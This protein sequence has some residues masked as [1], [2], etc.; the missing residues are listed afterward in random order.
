MIK[1]L[2][3]EVTFCD[4][5]T[6]LVF[7]ME[8]ENYHILQEQIQTAE[9]SEDISNVCKFTQPF[10]VMDAASQVGDFIQK[11]LKFISQVNRR[12]REVDILRCTAGAACGPR[13]SGR[14]AWQITGH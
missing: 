11:T 5:P 10:P 14:E 6:H 7:K 9:M 2:T 1:A 4:D 12:V 3:P 13:P 8:Y